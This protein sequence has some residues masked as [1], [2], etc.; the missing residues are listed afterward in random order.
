MRLFRREK[1][2]K[3]ANTSKVADRTKCSIPSTGAPASDNDKQTPLHLAVRNGK[4]DVAKTL[5]KKGIG[6]HAEDKDGQK[7]I[8]RILADKN[9]DTELVQLDV[10]K[11]AQ[12]SEGRTPLHKAVSNGQAKMARSLVQPKANMEATTQGN[13]ILHQAARE[14]NTR[15]SLVLNYPLPGEL[16]SIPFRYHPMAAQRSNGST[17]STWSNA[18]AES[19]QSRDSYQP[20]MRPRYTASTQATSQYSYYGTSH[21]HNYGLEI[22]PAPKTPSEKNDR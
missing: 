1:K 13:T 10:T 17:D 5:L 6:K 11:E 18:S 20:H 21:S 14:G 22:S 3:T 4:E 15:A 8:T 12:D 19:Y 16:Y 9:A 2:T 7:G